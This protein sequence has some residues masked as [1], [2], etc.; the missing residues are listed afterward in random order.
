MNVATVVEGK[1][2]NDGKST[3]QSEIMVPQG[4]MNHGGKTRSMCIRGPSRTSREQAEA[5]GKR[6]NDAAREGAKECR[7]VANQMQ[8]TKKGQHD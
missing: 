7:A 2:Q 5:D 6:L 8:R 1:P 4:G 3:F